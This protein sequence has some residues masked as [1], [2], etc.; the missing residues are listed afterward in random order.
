MG[1]D[2]DIDGSMPVSCCVEKRGTHGK[3]VRRQ[4]KER[5]VSG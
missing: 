1:S 4:G 5:K 2:Q 3:K